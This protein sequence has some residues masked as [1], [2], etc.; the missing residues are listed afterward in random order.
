MVTLQGPFLLDKKM[1]PK[2]K[3]QYHHAHIYFDSATL[4]KAK[5]L[6]QKLSTQKKWKLQI[7][8]LIGKPIGPHPV[9]MF[10]ADFLT[11]DFEDFVTYLNENRD[12]LSILVHPVTEEEVLDHTSRAT[13]LGESLELDIGFLEKFMA[14]KVASVQATLHKN[15]N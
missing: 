15:K 14:G 8:E 9:P 10:E 13:W 6:H 4:S 1:K 11:D 3:S 7:S 12:G 2:F 5:A